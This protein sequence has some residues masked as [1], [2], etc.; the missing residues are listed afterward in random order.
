VRRALALVLLASGLKLLGLNDVAMVATL[1]G[2]VV[3]GPLLWM[4]ARARHGLPPR[5]RILTRLWRRGAGRVPRPP[6]PVGRRPVSTDSS[7]RVP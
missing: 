4:W 1:G 3:L 5:P 6:D 7:A 2:V